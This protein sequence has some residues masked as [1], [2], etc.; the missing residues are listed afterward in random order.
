MKLTGVS[1]AKEIKAVR[2]DSN[3]VER[4]AQL[5]AL[6]D[7]YETSVYAR[8]TFP[9]GT[10]QRSLR[11]ANHVRRLLRRLKRDTLQL[12]REIRAAETVPVTLA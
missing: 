12:S 3:A 7:L 4:L 1:L 6:N 8:F 9:S 11:E 5:L 2:K 10:A